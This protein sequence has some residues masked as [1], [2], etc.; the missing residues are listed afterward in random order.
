MAPSW[1]AMVAPPARA[2]RGS[3]TARRGGGGRAGGGAGGGEREGAA[4]AGRAESLPPRL[5][6]TGVVPVGV[7]TRDHRGRV[8]RT[9]RRVGG[10]RSRCRGSAGS[11]VRCIAAR[12]GTRLC[13]G[14]VVA[15]CNPCTAGNPRKP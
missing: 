11:S 14:R 4:D 10:F 15:A 12:I 7:G 1:C 9:F 3:A 6:R 8:V 13:T 5:Q 2:P